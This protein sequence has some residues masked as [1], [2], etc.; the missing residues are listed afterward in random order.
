VIGLPSP[1]L[2]GLLRS[3]AEQ[4]GHEIAHVHDEDRIT[5]RELDERS[6]EIALR[7]V[8]AGVGKRTRVGLLLPNGIEWAV[9][10]CAI[11]RVGG[12]LVPLST[13][14]R[15]P[16]LEAQL[17][18]ASVSHLVATRAH[19]GRDHLADLHSLDPELAELGVARRRHPRLPA[20]RAV[21]SADE[22]PAAV[23]PETLVEGL[24][25]SVRPSDDLAILFTSG[26]R[27]APKGCVHTH[28]NALRA[29]ASGLEARCIGRGERLYIPMPFFWTGGF[30]GGLLTALVAGAT[31]LTESAATPAGTLAFLE[32]ERATLFRG[33][34]DQATKVAADPAFATAD[35]SSLG[36]ASLGALLP[37]TLRPQPGARA[38]LFGMTETFGPWCGSRL[39]T[40][41][42]KDKWGSCGEPFPGVEVRIVDPATGEPLERGAPGEIAV[43]GQNLMRGIVG[44]LRETVFTRDGF[45]R[46]G[47]L[48]ILDADGYLFYKGRADDMFKVSGATV[49]PSE[50]EAALRTVPGVAQ[51]FVTDLPGAD[52]DVVGAAVV[53]SASLAL[54]DLDRE[55]RKRLSAFK[56]PKRWT[57]LASLRDVPTLATG[58]IDKAGLQELIRSSGEPA[59]PR[60]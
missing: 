59:P 43:R 54:A 55:A 37:E 18:G 7:L 8:A 36:P 9:I 17:R 40:D 32:R 58:K 31:L 50:V 24:E 5:F 16:E 41:L 53:T 33:W 39:D 14:L 22:L 25:A 2:P 1:T 30:S 46:T 34:P 3:R 20:L 57:R 12:V 19:R 51:V 38:N 11:A 49:Y 26:S 6:R 4:L 23:A 42:P 21:W 15:P 29:V 60:A 44:R 13:L 47:D 45:Y 56:V 48:G 10:A 52:G 27:G 28:G 35:L